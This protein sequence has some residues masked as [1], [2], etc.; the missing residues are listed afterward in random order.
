MHSKL[1]VF[2]L[3]VYAVLLLLRLFPRSAAPQVAFT[4]FG[5]APHK[6]EAWARFQLRWAAYSFWWLAQI[7]VVLCF[8]AVAADYR[9][10]Q[11]DPWFQGLAFACALGGATAAGATLWFLLTALKARV[12]GPNPT[13]QPEP[14]AQ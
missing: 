12:V 3:A 6:D 13:F 14:P 9:D 1:L 4:W 5:P 10:S 2:W 7:A 8:A 11:D